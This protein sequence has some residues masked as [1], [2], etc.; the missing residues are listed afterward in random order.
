MVLTCVYSIVPALFK[1]LTVPLLW[2][3]ELS[4][5]KVAQLQAEARERINTDH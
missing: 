4:E 3:Y 2:N 1:I 5:E